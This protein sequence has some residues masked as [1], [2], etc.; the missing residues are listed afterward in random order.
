MAKQG[1]R[2]RQPLKGQDQLRRCRF[3]REQGDEADRRDLLGFGSKFIYLDFIR[4]IEAMLR[5]LRLNI[6]FQD[7][8]YFSRRGVEGY[9]YPALL[10]IHPSYVVWQAVSTRL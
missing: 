7:C 4:G 2:Q 3:K 6:K 10:E 5:S 1:R 8:A 9:E